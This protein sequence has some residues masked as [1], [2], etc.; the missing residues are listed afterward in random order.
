M[1]D[2]ESV[3]RIDAELLGASGALLS[4]DL[5]LGAAI[6]R[7]AVSATEH[8]A[9]TLD[10]LVRLEMADGHRLRAVELCEQLHL[11]PS[12][13]SRMLD[14]AGDAGLIERAPD[15]SDRRAKTVTLTAEGR[16]TV[17][18]F[19]PLLHAV[20]EQTV[21]TALTPAEIEVLVEMLGKIERASRELVDPS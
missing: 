11:S 21:H 2:R 6:E 18:A 15:P 4:A 14:R 20:L 7:L 19:A 3:P 12:H 1:A 13:V 9:T 10:L 17:D 16:A 8:D 5:A